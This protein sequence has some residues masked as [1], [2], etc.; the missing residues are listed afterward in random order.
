MKAF[1]LA[2]LLTLSAGIA[3]GTCVSSPSD[4]GGNLPFTTGKLLWHSYTAYGDGSSQLFVRDL[5]AGSTT[6]I[7][8]AWACASG[9]TVKDPMNG[10]FSADGSY[11][12]FMGVANNAWNVFAVPTAGGTPTNLTNS[13]GLTRN[14]DPKFSADGTKLIWKQTQSTTYRILSAPISLS[15]TPALGTVTTVITGSTQNSMPFE[16]STAT[17]VYY[18]PGSG[19]PFTVSEQ[20][21]AGG[22]VTTLTTSGYYPIDRWSDDT[23]FWADDTT[24]GANDQIAYKAVGGSAVI[25]SINDCNG[26][27][28]DPW[29]VASTTY[30]FFSSTT[31]GG[32]QLYLGDLATGDRY[33]LSSF[34]TDTA[35]AHLGSAYYSGTGGGGGGGGSCPTS[36]TDVNLSQGKTATA[37]SYS[38]ISGTAL[39][40]SRAFDG[41]TTS[42]RWDST[43]PMPLP[44]WLEVD[45]GALHHVDGIDL[46][47][48]SAAKDYEIDV[49]TDGTSW[50][51]IYSTTS[52]TS[53]HHRAIPA[54]SA[55]GRYVRIY[56]TQAQTAYGMALWEMQ[57][58][59]Y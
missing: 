3:H 4:T 59:G 30:V 12:V 54:L 9:C 19:A 5:A 51:S 26:N 48:D 23:V 55:C 29:P 2:L 35:K 39:V 44:S 13:T 47:W 14:E 27:N 7:S 57:V 40:V 1:L 43:E 56:G 33:N 32:Y 28:S 11:I 38:T 15:G 52:E 42:T 37:S 50:T 6:Q 41:N 21:M 20:P 22:T 49:S 31:P 18:S 46:Y 24:Q 36:G 34:Y 8:S 25:P 16:D 10:V 53:Y 58:W 45:L 17:N